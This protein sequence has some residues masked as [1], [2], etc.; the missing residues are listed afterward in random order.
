MVIQTMAIKNLEV[1]FIMINNYFIIFIK[2]NMTQSKQKEM[3]L[4][5]PKD[6]SH[7]DFI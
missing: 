1:F 7:F 5:S 3:S 2:S 4:S 6:N